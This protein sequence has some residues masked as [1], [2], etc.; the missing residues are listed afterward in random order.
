MLTEG[1]HHGH[2]LGQ[3]EDQISS[4]RPNDTSR[5]GLADDRMAAKYSRN[6]LIPVSRQPTHIIVSMR[7]VHS[8]ATLPSLP[9]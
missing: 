8:D 5:Q 7:L 9:T 6:G 2:G 3:S 1:F 4:P